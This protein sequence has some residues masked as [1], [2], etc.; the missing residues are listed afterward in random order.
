[1]VMIDPRAPLRD[2]VELMRRER[3]GSL[4][5]QDASGLRGLLTERDVA[6]QAGKEGAARAA[7]AQDALSFSEPVVCS[8]NDLVADALVILKQHGI[9]AVPV[10]DRRGAVVGVLSLVDAA[11]SLLPQTAPAWLDQVRR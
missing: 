5:V 9:S 6:A 7:T 10:L 8:E 2:A 4:L 3:V 1:M 11:A